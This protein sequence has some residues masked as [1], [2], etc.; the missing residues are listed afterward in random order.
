MIKDDTCR[1]KLTGGGIEVTIYSLGGLI[2]SI[3]VPNKEG[4]YADISLGQDAPQGEGQ[5]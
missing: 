2:Q 5:I 4:C 1:Y 3:K